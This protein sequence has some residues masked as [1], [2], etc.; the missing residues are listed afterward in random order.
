[1]IVTI[2]IFC[3]DILSRRKLESLNITPSLI[4]RLLH[5]FSFSLPDWRIWQLIRN[6]R[7]RNSIFDLCRW[8]SQWRWSHQL[9]YQATEIQKEGCFDEPSISWDQEK[10]LF[11][12]AFA[13]KSK[14]RMKFQNASFC[15]AGIVLWSSWN[16]GPSHCKSEV[17]TSRI[18]DLQNWLGWLS[19]NTGNIG[20]M[21]PVI[22]NFCHLYTLLVIAIFNCMGFAIHQFVHAAGVS[23]LE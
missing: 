7:K 5:H 12:F 6:W 17:Y 8:H 13:K 15:L 16:F 23:T 2:N 1:M 4:I 14:A 9:I 10:E 18:V 22:F 19:P 3:G 21:L 20:W 11:L